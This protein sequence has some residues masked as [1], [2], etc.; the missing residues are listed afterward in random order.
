MSTLGKK[1]V[2]WGLAAVAGIAVMSLNET[3]VTNGQPILQSAHA[4]RGRPATPLSYAGVARRT[5]RR[6]YGAAS[7]GCARVAGPYGVATRCY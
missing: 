5:T 6:A 1:F 7:G 4:V 2:K 3:L